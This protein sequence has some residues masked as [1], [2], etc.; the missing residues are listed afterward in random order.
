MPRRNKP[1][2][3]PH[4]HGATIYDGKFNPRCYGCAFAG[5]GFVCMTSDGRC[6]KDK[7]VAEDSKDAPAK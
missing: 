3:E 1:K 5:V 2:K 4:T 6:L 7:P